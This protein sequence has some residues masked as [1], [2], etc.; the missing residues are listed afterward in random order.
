[1]REM[2][3]LGVFKR[4]SG[5]RERDQVWQQITTNLNGYPNYSVTLRAIRERFTTIMRKYVQGTG[6]GGQELTEYETL[7]E[8]LIERYEESELKSEQEVA[9]KKS[10]EKDKQTALD[11]RKTA[12]ERYGETKKRREM[13]GENQLK[14]K[15]VKK[16]QLR[17]ANFSSSKTG[18]W[19][20]KIK[21]RTRTKR[22]RPDNALYQQQMLDRQMQ[23]FQLVAQ[24]QQQQFMAMMEFMN[25]KNNWV[26]S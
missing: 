15:K 11:I 5:S 10:I 20:R 1:M 26:N 21:A 14:E 13:E 7:L 25:K 4:K 8:D 17:Y 19:Q 6:L 16:N 24:Q 2:A 22:D 3:S 12:V 9:D 23:N 18:V